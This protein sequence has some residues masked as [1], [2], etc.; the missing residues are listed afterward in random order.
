[1]K[2]AWALKK[3]AAAEDEIESDGTWA[4]SYGDMI[5]LLLCFFLIFFTTDFKKQKVEKINRHLSFTLEGA[6]ELPSQAKIVPKPL[7]PNLG[8]PDMKAEVVGDS[9]VI[10]FGKI[11]FFKSG[12]VLVHEDGKKLLENFAQKF[13][14]YAG[15]YRV[16]LKAFTDKRQ[17]RK[18]SK[19]K[20]RKY[21]DNLELSALRSLAAIRILQRSGL[22]LNRMEIAGVG[23][24]QMIS[25][26]LPHTEDL[27]AVELQ[28]LSRT[29]VI[30]VMPE[31]DGLI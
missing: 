28:A 20:F 18:P 25:S 1:M 17:V 16:S 21:E 4:L 5:T 22:P 6:T 10:T 3:S 14:P 2:S 9:V 26:I 13:L 8:I 11:S 19:G 23:E 31:K 15:N 29:I 27:T 30:V 12:E 24:L 7:L